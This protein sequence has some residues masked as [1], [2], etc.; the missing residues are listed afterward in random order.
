LNIIKSNDNDSRKGTVLMEGEYTTLKFKCYIGHPREV[1]WNALTDPKEIALWFNTKAII[2]GRKDGSIDFISAPAG[3][4][5]TGR[6]LVWDPPHIF[7][8]EWHIA[9]HPSRMPKGE[10]DSFIRWELEEKEENNTILSLTF[11]RLTKLT[12]LGFAPGLHSFLD[13]LEAL[14]DKELLLLDGTIC[15][16]QRLTF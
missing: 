13:R 9:P 2:D 1:V 7:E 15:S 16:G 14:L 6:I 5:T 8:H 11:S 10:P 3:F 12:G 4:H